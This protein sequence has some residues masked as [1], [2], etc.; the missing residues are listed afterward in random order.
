MHE[1]F[2]HGFHGYTQKGFKVDEPLIGANSR[3]WFKAGVWSVG[4]ISVN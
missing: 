3:S 2:N 4:L 1:G